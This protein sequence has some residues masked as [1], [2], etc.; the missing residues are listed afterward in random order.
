MSIANRELF[1]K[2]FTY[3]LAV[4]GVRSKRAIGNVSN[5]HRSYLLRSF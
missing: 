2:D 1:E 3:F 4:D 5:T